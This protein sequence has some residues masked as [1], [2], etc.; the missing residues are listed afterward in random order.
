MIAFFDI[1]ETRGVPL[2]VAIQ[3]LDSK[4]MVPDWTGFYEEALKHG[5]KP[6][7]VCLRLENVIADVYGPDYLK[8]WQTRMDRYL[9][10]RSG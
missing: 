6:N 3:Y 5:W 9:A 8:E 10:G 2:D 1:V 4:G 7:R